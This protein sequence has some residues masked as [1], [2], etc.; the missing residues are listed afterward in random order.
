MMPR[1]RKD[2]KRP[3]PI[4]DQRNR[5][6]S[7]GGI[8]QAIK[9]SPKYRKAPNQPKPVPTFAQ[10]TPLSSAAREIV[11]A[12]KNQRE[13]FTE[14]GIRRRTEALIRRIHGAKYLEDI[15]RKDLEAL[16]SLRN[17]RLTRQLLADKRSKV[18]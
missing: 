4:I 3:L 14:G 1:R 5:N 13:R 6:S 9:N 2:Q 17:P 16:R 7:F 8:V 18:E 11:Q 15:S 10:N 12:T